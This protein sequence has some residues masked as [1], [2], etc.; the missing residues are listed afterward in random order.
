VANIALATFTLLHFGLS[1][2]LPR[3]GSVFTD[4]A[5]STHRPAS[6]FNRALPLQQPVPIHSMFPSPG[7]SLYS[8]GF[9]AYGQCGVGG[10]DWNEYDPA[11]L[12]PVP[13]PTPVTIDVPTPPSTPPTTTLPAIASPRKQQS[14]EDK[15][16]DLW[17]SR[18][19]GGGQVVK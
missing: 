14:Q 6:G 2:A 11:A 3:I 8:W 13:Y 15:I 9:N 17:S 10:E 19:S 16:W 18:G 12:P 7:T 1:L 4:T 5:H